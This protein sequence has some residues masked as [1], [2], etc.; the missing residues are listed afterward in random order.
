MSRIGHYLGHLKAYKGQILYMDTL[1]TK[2]PTVVFVVVEKGLPWQQ[3]SIS[4][5][6]LSKG[7]G[8]PDLV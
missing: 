7:I 5:S 8:G 2:L 4:I 6:Q 3:R 1:C